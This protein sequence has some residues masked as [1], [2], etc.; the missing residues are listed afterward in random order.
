MN[1]KE[2]IEILLISLKEAGL[3]RAAVEE[4]LKLSPNAIT[5][6][7]SRGGNKK[8]YASVKLL[9]D[10]FLRN[11]INEVAKNEAQGGQNSAGTVPASKLIAVLEEQN[12]FLRRNFETSLTTILE[13]QQQAGNQL[14]ALT[15]YSALVANGRDEKKA[16]ADLSEIHN[17]IASFEGVG[18]EDDSS[19][20]NDK[21]RTSAKR[22]VGK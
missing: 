3:G 18:D 2:E 10:S 1:Y 8:L 6:A 19:Q 5:Q 15:W 17:N 7:L 22:K 12:A 14:G 11:A 13:V 20:T 9:A 16:A 4:K 21:K